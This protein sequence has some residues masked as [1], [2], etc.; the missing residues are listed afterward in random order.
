MQNHMLNGFAW[1][2]RIKIGGGQKFHHTIVAD[3][4]R[5]ATSKTVFTVAL[6]GFAVQKF[7]HAKPLVSASRAA[8]VIR[9]AGGACA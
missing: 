2:A 6:Y 3:I 7:R 1:T 9:D 5:L 8:A 4:F